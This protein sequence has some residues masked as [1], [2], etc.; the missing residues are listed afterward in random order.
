MK[1]AARKKHAAVTEPSAS[2]HAKPRKPTHADDNHDVRAPAEPDEQPSE[3][4]SA[5]SCCASVSSL[6]LARYERLPPP[7][8]DHVRALHRHFARR[9]RS[10]RSLEDSS[11]VDDHRVVRHY[12]RR[13]VTET[14]AR[15]YTARRCT[16]LFRYALMRTLLARYVLSERDAL[17][18][19]QCNNARGGT[20]TLRSVLFT[21]KR[22]VVFSGVERRAQATGGHMQRP[23]VVKWYQSDERTIEQETSVY[24]RLDR[25][26]APT[27]WFSGSYTF[28]NVWRTPVL[29]LEQLRKL[30]ER[31]DACAMGVQLLE[32][33]RVLHQFGLHNDIKPGNVM[34]RDADAD[35]DHARRYFLIDHGGVAERA[36]AYGRERRI[37]TQKFASQPMLEWRRDTR[38]QRE[39]QAHARH[40]ISTAAHDLIELGYTLAA[41]CYWSMLGAKRLDQHRRRACDCPCGRPVPDEVRVTSTSNYSAQHVPAAVRMRVA[42]QYA[43]QREQRAP[44]QCTARCCRDKPRECFC[45]GACYL[46]RLGAVRRPSAAALRI[47]RYAECVEQMDPRQ[48]GAEQYDRLAAILAAR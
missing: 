1:H 21:G 35:A 16:L 2:R 28:E 44:Q 9:P 23:V 15:R 7:I 6:V 10:K 31:D 14:R 38:T 48:V 33:L 29:V 43:Q 18:R 32:Q 41:V 4:A 47:L 27:P 19:I 8:R 26:G 20:V 39:Y 3:S 42:Q 36:L 45:S 13:L 34:V 30:D 22:S 40:Q 17:A 37:W 24:D 46:M 11:H 25:L 5:S 12:Y